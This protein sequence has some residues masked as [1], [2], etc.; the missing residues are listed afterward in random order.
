[1]ATIREWKRDFIKLPKWQKF[2]IVSAIIL[3]L[4]GL[5]FGGKYIINYNNIEIRNS[6]LINSPIVQGSS[7]MTFI[8]TS[9]TYPNDAFD[10][11]FYPKT[12]GINMNNFIDGKKVNRYF[13]KIIIPDS[14]EVFLKEVLFNISY[15]IARCNEQD[16]DCYV[17]HKFRTNENLKEDDICWIYTTRLGHEEIS[18]DILEFGK[19]FMNNPESCYELV[20]D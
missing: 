14:Q 17:Y 11:F 13:M 10:P 9:S 12:F 7:N 2:S 3:A 19:R 6:N 5:F 8:Y 15:D 4:I 18:S 16:T 1:M 20:Q